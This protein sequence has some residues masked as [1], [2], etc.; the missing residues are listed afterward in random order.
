MK[1]N[2]YNSLLQLTNYLP[3][4]AR[5]YLLRE[6]LQ[7]SSTSNKYDEVEI[8]LATTKKDIEQSFRLVKKYY[9]K[10]KIKNDNANLFHITKFHCLPT[11]K[12]IVAKYKGEIIGTMTIILDSE[13]KLPIDDFSNIGKLRNSGKKIAEISSI[14]VASK[15]RRRNSIVFMKLCT[16]LVR[17]SVEVM[18]IDFF[19]MVTSNTAR[20]YYKEIF[21]FKPIDGEIKRA[22]HAGNKLSYSQ[23][24]NTKT[25]L[26]RMK[27]NYSKKKFEKITEFLKSHDNYFH[28]FETD[29]IISQYLYTREAFLDFF[30]DKNNILGKLSK[31]EKLALKNFY[32]HTSNV[33]QSIESLNDAHQKQDR[34]FPRYHAN[35]K[36]LALCNKK[37]IE[38]KTLEVSR[39]GLSIISDRYHQIG[40]RLTLLIEVFEGE[41]EEFHA[42]VRW[43]KGSR[44]GLKLIFNENSK[45]QLTKKKWHNFMN[46]IEGAANINSLAA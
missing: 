28:Q 32:D 29:K 26:K 3:S 21:C 18:G 22:S 34:R 1:S 44:Y 10:S 4:E 37:M 30:R 43:T 5:G 15:W 24:A 41:V 7:L 38:G 12:I 23:Y 16:F 46:K 8:G 20:H 13:F 9:K 11:T 2:I 45:I 19:V 39:G 35:Y 17:Y 27:K 33:H 6:F 36:L 40:D 25:M 31:N 14:A 42:H